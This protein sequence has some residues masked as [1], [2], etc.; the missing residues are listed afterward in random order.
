MAVERSDMIIDNANTK[1]TITKPGLGWETSLDSRSMQQ[2][3]VLKFPG[4]NPKIVT[5]KHTIDVDE[6]AAMI[7]VF[8]TNWGLPLPNKRLQEQHLVL[9]DSWQNIVSAVRTYVIT[10]N[11]ISAGDNN[12]AG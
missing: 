10:E 4:P 9:Q 11:L 1:F 7:E 3:T 2:G 6:L 5:D 8:K 12:D